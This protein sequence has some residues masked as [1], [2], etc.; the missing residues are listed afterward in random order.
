MAKL[1]WSD[2]SGTVATI[3]VNDIKNEKVE[4]S[5]L[6]GHCSWITNLVLTRLNDRSFILT[7][8]RDEKIR[9]SNYPDCYDILCYCLGHKTFISAVAVIERRTD[10]WAVSGGSDN[11]LY[12]WDILKGKLLVKFELDSKFCSPEAP[13]REIVA[14]EES[15][16]AVL[17]EDQA[18]VHIFDIMED[19]GKILIHHFKSIELTTE[20]LAIQKVNGILWISTLEGLFSFSEKLVQID[21]TT[22]LD[23]MMQKRPESYQEILSSL[24]CKQFKKGIGS[25]RPPREGQ[26]PAKKKRKRVGGK[27]ANTSTNK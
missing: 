15:R 13:I 25:D 6:L 11:A 23:S 14:L 26:P 1:I 24:S 20:P 16:F 8:D 5:V 18:R 7:G 4:P 12:V 21:L 9:I 2:R 10:L 19:Q 3:D 27:N 17:I 22:Q